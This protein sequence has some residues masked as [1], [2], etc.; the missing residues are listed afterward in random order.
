MFVLI[1]WSPRTP[2][3]PRKRSANLL[4]HIL[5]SART[6]P[7]NPSCDTLTRFGLVSEK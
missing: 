5:M 7:N 2:A 6:H 4:Q 1:A 3:T